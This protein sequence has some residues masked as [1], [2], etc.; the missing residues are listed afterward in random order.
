MFIGCITLFSWFRFLFDA[1]MT[2]VLGIINSYDSTSNSSRG[3]GSCYQDCK[4]NAQQLKGKPIS[5]LLLKK[6]RTSSSYVVGSNVPLPT[7]L[8]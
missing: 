5:Y 2:S 4:T 1:G 3:C 8:R 6:A 7:R